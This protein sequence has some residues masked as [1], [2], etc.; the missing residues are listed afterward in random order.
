MKSRRLFIL[1]LAVFSLSACSKQIE[2][3]SATDISKES[4][5]LDTVSKSIENNTCLDSGQL[6]YYADVTHDGIADDI[7]IDCKEIIKDSQAIAS[8]KVVTNSDNCIWNAELG[9]PHAGWGTYYLVNIDDNYYLLLNMPE[10]SQGMYADYYR[11]FYFSAEGAEIVVDEMTLD[12]V[13]E[14]MLAES[15]EKYYNKVNKYIE[16]GELLIST[17]EGE[18]K[19]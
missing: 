10:E 13:D 14:S 11:L 2:T 19:Y 9:L 15:L 3:L 4:E 18:L 1:I 12:N 6:H 17:W 16:S 8:I 5:A 7:C